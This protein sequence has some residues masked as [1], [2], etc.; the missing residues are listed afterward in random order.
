[1]QI[2]SDTPSD[3][4]AVRDVVARA[5]VDQP[6]VADLVDAIRASENYVGDLALVAEL[7]GDIV[8]FVMCSYATLVDR[9][10]RHRVL[11]LSPLAVAPGQ[12]RR[13]IG[14]ALVEAVADRAV[15]RGE[16]LIVLEGS[17]DY[18]GRLGFEHST[19]YGIEIELPSWAPPEAAQV[20]RLP[21]Y[22]PAVRGRLEVP[23]TS[24]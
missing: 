18:Y 23:W 17:P 21:A 4:P 6:E 9:S 3:H 1:M 15:A 24:G 19:T 11:T 22:D 13:G 2:R 16:P 5:F 8:G 12:Q 14:R 20:R 7:D 10:N